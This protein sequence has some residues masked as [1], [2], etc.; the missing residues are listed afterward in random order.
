MPTYTEK[1]INLGDALERMGGELQLLRREYGPV[2]DTQQELMLLNLVNSIQ[3]SL[4]RATDIIG[5]IAQTGEGLYRVVVD[6]P[7][8]GDLEGVSEFL[9]ECNHRKHA[10]NKARK[11]GL[12]I[13]EI[14]LVEERE[15]Q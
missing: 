13:K 9:W 4:E 11:R 12:V 7:T 14:I 10:I 1:L 5:D 15:V 6:P 3:N 8:F 2:V